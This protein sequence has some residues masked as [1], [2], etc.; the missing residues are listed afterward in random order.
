MYQRAIITAAAIAGLLVA[1]V[2]LLSQRESVRADTPNL[3]VTGAIYSGT[4]AENSTSGPVPPCYG[5]TGG[6][7]TGTV[8]L[9]A[10]ST[11]P[12]LYANCNSSSQC[13]LTSAHP[14]I[15]ITIS[16][17]ALF[18]NTNYS[19]AVTIWTTLAG[20]IGYCQPVSNTS[21]NIYM[22]NPTS[23]TVTSGTPVTINWVA[24][25]G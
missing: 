11:S 15:T 1:T 14:Y 12:S 10:D 7:C 13:Q 4:T 2:T 16:N 17:A 21:F 22:Y 25:G 19:C 3:S 24:Q 9:V 20:Y 5:S 6:A 18:S 23:G 8:H